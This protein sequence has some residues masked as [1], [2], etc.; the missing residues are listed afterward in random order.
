M[1]LQRVL[2][3]LFRRITHGLKGDRAVEKRPDLFQYL[4]VGLPAF[5]NLVGVGGNTVHQTRADQ[6]RLGLRLCG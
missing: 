3:N 4:G 1:D 5:G 6:Y 2:D